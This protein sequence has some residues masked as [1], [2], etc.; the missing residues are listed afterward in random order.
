MGLSE[1]VRVSKTRA[2]RWWEQPDGVNNGKQGRIASPKGRGGKIPCPKCG[3]F[4][5]VYN[6]NY[7]CDDWGGECDWALPHPALSKRDREFCD[8][9]GIDYD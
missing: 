5:V 9:V 1:V 6:G 7:F 2:A 8:L 4:P 3:V